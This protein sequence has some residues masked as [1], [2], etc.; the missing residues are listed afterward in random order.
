MND[1]ERQEVSKV[2]PLKD[3]EIFRLGRYPDI[4]TIAI[5]AMSLRFYY[6]SLWINGV[7]YSDIYRYRIYNGPLDNGSR[8]EFITDLG[9]S[10]DT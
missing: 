9:D 6:Q 8:V 10:S 3:Q 1:F 7:K 2:S 4:I 5:C